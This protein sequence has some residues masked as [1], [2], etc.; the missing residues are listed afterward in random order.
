MAGVNTR[1]VFENPRNWMPDDRIAINAATLIIEAA[2]GARSGLEVTD[3]PERLMLYS[4]LDDGSLEAPYDYLA[5]SSS[6]DDLFGGILKPEADGMF[7]LDTLYVYRFNMGLHFQSMIDGI[8]PD[9]V[10]RLQLYDP[11]VN[12][13]FSLLFGNP[14]REHARIRLEIVY[15]K[16]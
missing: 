14:D 3:L 8:K 6:D 9:S 10:F 12:P 16:L 4:E 7:D 5:L 1:L 15:L 13:S 11:L 2:P